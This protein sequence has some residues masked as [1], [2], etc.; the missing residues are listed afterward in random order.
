MPVPYGLGRK[1]RFENPPDPLCKRGRENRWALGTGHRG[2]IGFSPLKRACPEL[3]EGG[4]RGD[5]EM[6][7]QSMSFNFATW[8]P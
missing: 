6:L 7:W 8:S 1:A 4:D 3:V 2:Y 5:F